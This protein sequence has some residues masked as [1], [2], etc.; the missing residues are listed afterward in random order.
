MIKIFK[1]FELNA[2]NIWA[3]FFLRTTKHN[4][5]TYNI[6]VG[7]NSS[8]LKKYH[9]NCW[10]LLIKVRVFLSVIW[11]RDKAHLIHTRF[12]SKSVYYRRRRHFAEK[13]LAKNTKTGLQRSTLFFFLFFRQTQLFWT[14]S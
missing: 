7:E 9:E 13:L 3:I 6:L 4:T 14:L 8:C 1:H 12:I 2:Q 10:K 11:V 5:V